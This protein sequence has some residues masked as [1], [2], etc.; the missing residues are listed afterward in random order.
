[1]TITLLFHCFRRQIIDNQSKV[2][3]FF[4]PIGTSRIVLKS[5]EKQELK[6]KRSRCESIS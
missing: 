4:L 2:E 1:M 5:R 6:P 3:T